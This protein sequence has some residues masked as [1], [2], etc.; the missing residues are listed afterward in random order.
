MKFKHFLIFLLSLFVSQ[1]VCAYT[2]TDGNGLSWKFKLEG[3]GAILYNTDNDDIST[4]ESYPCIQGVLP[5]TLDSI[6]G[7]C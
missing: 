1:I 2:W 5:E 3:G 4:S 6:N 7:K